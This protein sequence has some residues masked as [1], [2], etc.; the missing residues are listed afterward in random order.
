MRVWA[1]VWEIHSGG[2]IPPKKTQ[3]SATCEQVFPGDVL[4]FFVFF[5]CVFWVFGLC[6]GGTLGRLEPPKTPQQPLSPFG[7][8]YST[9]FSRRSCAAVKGVRGVKYI[10]GWDEPTLVDI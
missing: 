7:V 6:F 1:R 5:Y 10:L 4:V 8:A 9:R 3:V 2:R